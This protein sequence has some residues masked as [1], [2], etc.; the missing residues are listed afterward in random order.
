[1]HDFKSKLLQDLLRK[2]LEFNGLT[3]TD[4]THGWFLCSHK[5]S[6]AS[7]PFTI[8]A[9]CD[10]LLFNRVLEEDVQYMKEG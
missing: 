6:E 9:G 3:I 2:E 1:M 5:R 4:A 7:V 8:Q 10:M